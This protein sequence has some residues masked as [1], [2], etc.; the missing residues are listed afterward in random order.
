MARRLGKALTWRAMALSTAVLGAL[1]PERALAHVP[2]GVRYE[3][4][5]PLLAFVLGAGALGVVVFAGVAALV[6]QGPREDAYPRLDL[7]RWRVGRALTSRGAVVPL[8]VLTA[9]LFFLVIVAGFIGKQDPFANPAPV[10]IW[11]WWWVGVACVSGLVGDVWAVVNPWKNLYLWAEGAARKLGWTFGAEEAPG[12]Y[13]EVWE[14]WPAVAL[15]LAFAWLTIASGPVSEA[16]RALALFAAFYSLLTWS[17]MLCFGVRQWTRHGEV[18]SVVFRTLA[19]FAPTEVRVRN[20][21]LCASCPEG[22]GADGRP[23]TN[24]V[25][26]FQRARPD[27]REFNLRPH[28]TGL[29]VGPPARR[30]E[31]ALVLVLFAVVTLDAFLQTSLWTSLGVAM[32][33][34]FR[35]LGPESITAVYTIA[36][37]LVPAVTV[38]GYRL[39]TSAVATYSGALVQAEQVGRSMVYALV[40]LALAVFVAHY[41]PSL[42]VQGQLLIPLASDPFGLGWDLIGTA[43]YQPTMGMVSA[44]FV[45]YLTFGAV[46]TG[47]AFALFTAHARALQEMPSRAA[48]LR[49]QYPLLA[50]IVGYTMLILWALAQPITT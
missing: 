13:P 9:A 24:C 40:P 26:C 44:S 2:F 47:Q 42:L 48:A 34:Y 22:C 30:S 41:L 23:C 15:F 45:W 10:M 43:G 29:L 7:L 32:Y 35:W 20:E 27:E 50:A 6:R 1:V 18:F 3:L 36:V 12:L 11:L 31:K 25:S 37:A 17:G 5:V 4:P 19:R 39:L 28:G 14:L 16:P 49:G 8:Q 21:R 38:V 33:P 46:V